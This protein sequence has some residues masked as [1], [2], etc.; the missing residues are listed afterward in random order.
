EL[1]VEKRAVPKEELVIKKHQV[2]EEQV[3]E[4]DL[5]KERAEVHREGDVNVR[6]DRT[7]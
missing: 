4:A 5:R 7:R 3:V 6:G 2:Q 1:V